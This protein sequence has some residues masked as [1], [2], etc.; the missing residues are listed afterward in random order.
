VK[1]GAI[2]L[3]RLLRRLHLPTVRRLYAELEARAEKEEMSY[4]DYLAILIAEEVA[5]RGETRVRRSVH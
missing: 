1:P 4:R 2:D 5:H 3:E